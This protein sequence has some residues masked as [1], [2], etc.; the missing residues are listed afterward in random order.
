MINHPATMQMYCPDCDAYRTVPSPP[1]VGCVYC[2]MTVDP[3][4]GNG[5]DRH[6]D[7]VLCSRCQAL[8]SPEQLAAWGYEPAMTT[9]AERLNVPHEMYDFLKTLADTDGVTI[10]DVLK[11]GQLEV[12][13]AVARYDAT[14][15][16][17]LA[18][19]QR[20]IAIAE[21]CCRPMH[22]YPEGL[23]FGQ[24]WPMAG[25]T[26][27][28][29]GHCDPMN[30]TDDDVDRIEAAVNRALVGRDDGWRTPGAGAA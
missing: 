6:E 14:M 27:A 23:A 24:V 29:W 25:L 1:A 21:A 11:Y 8:Y 15:Q 28:D 22:A 12:A 10:Q 2:E 9:E 7:T 30:P 20:R 17:Q 26:A 19:S 16:G 4:F 5:D 3:A 18:A 13:T